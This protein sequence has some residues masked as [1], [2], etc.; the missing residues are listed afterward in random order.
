MTRSALSAQELSQASDLIG[1]IYDCVIDPTLWGPT[2]E[3]VQAA[4]RCAN[5]TLY[6]LDTEPVAA[7]TGVTRGLV[8]FDL[9]ILADGL[10]G[11]YWDFPTVIDGS[12]SMATMKM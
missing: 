7:D 5:A 9:S 10:E 4:I 8:D 6:V 12:T 11:Y 1:A 2:L 3:A